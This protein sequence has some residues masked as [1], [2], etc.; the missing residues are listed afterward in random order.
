MA[1][2]TTRPVIQGRRGVVTAGHYLAAAAGFRIMEAGG[3]A[4]DAAVATGVCL[5]VLEPHLTGIGGEVPILIYSSRQGRV[6][7]LS[8]QGVA[9]RA[10]TIDWF[11]SRG[12]SLIPGDGLLAAT[13]PAAVDT[14]ITALAEFGTLPL[15]QVLAPALSLASN[16]FPMYRTLRD[17]IAANA[18]RYREEWPTTARIFLPQGRVPAVGEILRQPDWAETFEKLVRAEHDARGRG[19]AA[20]L[21]A[22]RDVFYRGEIAERIAA[23]AQQTRVRDATGEAHAGLLTY[24]DLATWRARIEDPVTTNYRGIT[25]CKCGPWTQGPVFLQQ[26]NL[27]EGYDLAAL[28]HNSPDYIH[29]VTEAAKLAFADR[30]RYDGDPLFDDV[31][32]AMLLSKEYA[33]RRRAL[34]DPA[35]ASLEQGAGEAAPAPQTGEA[36]PYGGDT[37]HL[38]VIDAE[39]NM[40]SATP[41]GGWIPSSPVIDGLGFPLGTRAQM[42]YLEPGR[43][44]ALEPGKRP[45]TTL[46]PS[47]ALKEG[48]PWLAFGTPGGDCQDQWTL[49]FFLNV[50]DFGM[51][52]QE[53]IDAPTFHTQHFPSSFYPRQALPGRLNVEGR[54]AAET[55]QA[56]RE[57]GH[58]LAVSGDWEHGRVMGI[59]YNTETGVIA[60]AASP[61]LETGYCIG[62]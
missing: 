62:W 11:R 12:I 16:G 54:I 53:A 25:V 39:G 59:R 44:N 23:F 60:G 24:D 58:D 2:F 10:A 29:I 49:Q 33:A 20:A 6:F 57:R 52:L 48:K 27:L 50:V 7:S 21:Q 45:R 41:S 14:F 4:V 55:Q 18:A 31:P 61:R 19:R 37:T 36:L 5:E 15:G 46:T 56:L 43:P 28:G 9:P 17:N 38:D 40:V 35:R 1:V 26:L 8:G 42:F 34:I 3:N 30:E 47:L 51:D 32:L 13:V 22:A